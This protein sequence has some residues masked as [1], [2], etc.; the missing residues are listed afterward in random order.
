MRARKHII[1]RKSRIIHS[2]SIV[3]FILSLLLIIYSVSQITAGYFKEK[4]SLALW[5]SKIKAISFYN[6]VIEDAA[7]SN[8]QEPVGSNA[9]ASKI[10]EI[11]LT[12][13][14]L[15]VFNI[16][17]LNKRTA[18]LFGTE[19]EQLQ[20]GIGHLEESAAPGKMGNCVLAGHN[21]TVFHD[22]GELKKGDKLQIE[23][24]SKTYNYIVRDMK[25]VPPTDGSPL[26]PSNEGI[27]TLITCYPFSY[28]GPASQRYIVTAELE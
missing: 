2:V 18:I 16:P 21:D 19:P 20:K 26:K 3:I 4:Q 12:E 1:N 17:R 14:I 13:E 11:K 22:L 6:P 10:E 28:I 8:P 25:I 9:T 27:L 7:S 24:V 23:T 5:D 15:G